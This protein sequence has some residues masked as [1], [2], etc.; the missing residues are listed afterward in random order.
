MSKLLG[1]FGT[2]GV[3]VATGAGVVALVAGAYFSGLFG[4]WQA[5]PVT[6]ENTAPQAPAA[7]VQNQPSTQTTSAPDGAPAAAP[8]SP[9]VEQSD[10]QTEPAAPAD[11]ALRAPRFDLFRFDPATGLLQV[12][13]RSDAGTTV[14][15]LV[16]GAEIGQ[17]QAGGAG[18][19]YW[20]EPIGNAQQPRVLALIAR[21]DDRMMPSDQQMIIAPMP[22][23][24][25]RA[26]QTEP[27]TGGAVALVEQPASGTGSKTPVPGS[28]EVTQTPAQTPAVIMAD[29]DG[30]RLVQ[31]PRRADVAPEVMSTVALDAISY[32][33]TGAVELAGR[34]AGSGFVR[35]YLDNTPITSSR[36]A[37]DG[38]WRTALPDVDTGVYVLRVDEVTTEGTV[39]SRV[40]TPFKRE[41]QQVLAAVATAS[42]PQ[43]PPVPGGQNP[44]PENGSGVAIRAVT[45]Q[46]GSTLWAIAR[47]SYGD[48]VQYLRVY[49]ANRDRI[50][51]PDLI[52]PGQVFS[53]PQSAQQ[54]E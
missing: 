6:A 3:V 33:E 30:V 42:A 7:L 16:D 27:E 49:E 23:Q 37:S 10:P 4:G 12:A 19:F 31:P 8:Q 18:Q 2:N 53:V 51:D 5:G 13:G 35:V 25:A 26:P 34:G 44:A 46:P 43:D 50:R 47:D 21:S 39:V 48:G 20:E 40:E 9:T 41:D 1:V 24:T 22:V 38:N 14:S 28:T 36:I 11:L 54:G 45:V 29:Q 17:S 32:S 52:Y 15:I